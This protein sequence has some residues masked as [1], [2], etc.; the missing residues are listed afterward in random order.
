MEYPLLNKLYREKVSAVKYSI[1]KQNKIAT[2]EIS[3][4]GW[5]KWF[6]KWLETRNVKSFSFT[7]IS[8]WRTVVVTASRLI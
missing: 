3:T 8:S 4:I 1:N 5:L 6:F 7:I 2:Q